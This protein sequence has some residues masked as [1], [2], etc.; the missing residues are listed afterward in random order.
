MYSVFWKIFLGYW[1]LILFVELVTA[2]VTV[3]LS[4][5]EI[6]PILVK[7]NNEFVASSTMAVSVLTKSGLSGLKQWLGES[8]HQ[9]VDEIYILDSKRREVFSKTVPSD[10]REL[11]F[12]NSD[13]SHL[14]HKHLLKNVLSFRTV[15]PEG[16]DYML[17]ST[18]EHPHPIRYL[19]A[20]QRVIF[21][22]GL[23]GF[24]C[25]LLARYFTS[26]LQKLRE[27]THRITEG[28]F[29]IGLDQISE[30]KDEFG[31]LAK[32]FELM[33]RRLSELLGTQKQLL[34]DIS[35]ELR[36]PLSR[37]QVALDLARN[38]VKPNTIEELDRIE[39][40]I[41]RLEF[42]IRELLVFVRIENKS[43]ELNKVRVDLCELLGHVVD[44]VNYELGESRAVI[45]P[46]GDCSVDVFADIK[47]LHRALENIVR[48]ACYYSS[49]ESSV[50]V[51][52]RMRSDCVLVE[53]EDNGPG[54]PQQ[55]L[56]KIFEP[57]VRVS[58]ARESDSGG[59]GI[60]LAIA[61]RVIEAH[62]GTVLATNKKQGSGLLVTVALKGENRKAVKL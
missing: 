45:K 4:E 61:K 54:V 58:D 52:C 17:V 19:L 48:N 55:M 25:F 15:S 59:S 23:S 39:L 51:D 62:E 56:E 53:V 31:F 35:H 42:L 41:Q 14:H 43:K 10:I 34:R 44:D 28:K 6:H 2:W 30:R 47:L 1:G 26:P 22:I 8:N 9:A 27:S 37:L 50:N 32:D 60:G 36:S 5:Y 38:R 18:F 13:S 49:K 40:E 3:N 7:Q 57:F 12:A 16:E 46:Q 21:G 11:V 24:I 33:A 29:D 20:P